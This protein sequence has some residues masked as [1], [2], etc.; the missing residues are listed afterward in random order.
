MPFICFGSG[1]EVTVILLATASVP[2]QLWQ[3]SS[4]ILMT[5]D[6]AVPCF[7]LSKND[8]YVMSASGGKI[9]LFNMITFKTITT[10][11]PAPPAATF[12][13]FH[14]QDNNIIAIGMD[15]SCR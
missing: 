15:D 1:R 4:G 8:S 6:I 9:S 7:A 11:I 5:N 2:P 13:A 3:P 12:L 10:F 14:P